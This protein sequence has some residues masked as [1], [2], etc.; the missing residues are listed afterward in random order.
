MKTKVEFEYDEDSKKW[1]VYVYGVADSIE[2]IQA[3]NAVL[4]TCHYAKP[5]MQHKTEKQEGN[6]E[7]GLPGY[8]LIIGI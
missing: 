6:W 7:K 4:I 5:H 3:F 2:A 1:E 8:K